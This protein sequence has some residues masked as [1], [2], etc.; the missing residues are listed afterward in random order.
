MRVR[1]ESVRRESVRGEGVR[2]E[3]PSHSPS[4]SSSC[5]VQ[6]LPVHSTDCI[7]SYQRHGWEGG[8]GGR[9]AEEVREGGEESRE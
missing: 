6:Q 1:G 2:K 9:R 5:S 7:P 3:S 8:E 4:S